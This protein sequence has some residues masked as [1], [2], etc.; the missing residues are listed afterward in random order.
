MP[1]T[2][3]TLALEPWTEVWPEVNR[4]GEAHFAEVEGPLA[5]RRPFLLDA[6]Q[7]ELACRSGTLKIFTARSGRRLLGYLTWS[8][9]MD[10]ESA[11]NLIAQQGAWYVAPG[12]ACGLK[13][14]HFSLEWLRSSGVAFAFP[15][16]RALGRGARLGPV[17][18]RLGAVPIQTT[19]FLELRDA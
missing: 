4:L 13:L 5:T 12:E 14:L 16:H 3:L 18:R 11:G 9:L 15:H 19:Y 1:C 7:M 2:S 10:P 6:I 8:L 17:L